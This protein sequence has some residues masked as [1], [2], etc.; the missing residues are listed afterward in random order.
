MEPIMCTAVVDFKAPLP[1]NILEGFDPAPPNRFFPSM[2]STKWGNLVVEVWDNNT[3][4]VLVRGRKIQFDDMHDQIIEFFVLH[5]FPEFENIRNAMTVVA[6]NHG[7]Q[8][9][10]PPDVNDARLRKFDSGSTKIRR[11]QENVSKCKLSLVNLQARLEEAQA[12]LDAATLERD[13]KRC[14]FKRGMFTC[15]TVTL[16]HSEATI[17]PSGKCMLRGTGLWT[18]FEADVAELKETLTRHQK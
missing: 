2:R 18:D 4:A 11:L 16:P 17:L 5:K 13:A 10:L 9:E 8:V 15:K 12:L 7:K 1:D 3:Q 14:R 6:Y